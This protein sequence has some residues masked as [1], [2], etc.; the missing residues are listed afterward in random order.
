MI[1]HNPNIPNVIAWVWRDG[2]VHLEI[3]LATF[4]G[5]G[6]NAKTLTHVRDDGGT[7]KSLC[8]E[9]FWNK[10]SATGIGH[11]ERVDCAMC[12]AIISGRRFKVGQ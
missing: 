6:D 8:G 4:H 3:P 10:G 12:R 5:E 7:F 1:P 2:S 11:M 9:A